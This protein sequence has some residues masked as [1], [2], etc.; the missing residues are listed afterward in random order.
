MLTNSLYSKKQL[1]KE[2]IERYLKR[3]STLIRR[4]KVKRIDKRILSNYEK[5]DERI[6]RT[7]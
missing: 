1:I 3:I 4:N 7:I 5:T 6:T 2:D